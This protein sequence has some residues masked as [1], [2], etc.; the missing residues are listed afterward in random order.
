[1][2]VHMTLRKGETAE[3]EFKR[4]DAEKQDTK[5][6]PLEWWKV[7]ES[8][9]PRVAALAREYLA[10]PATSA[11]VERLFSSVGLVKTDDRPRLKDST[12][13]DIMW[14]KENVFE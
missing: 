9:F 13:V 2:I 5:C 8:K 10:A 12:L 7:N 6:H 1:M 14:V 4:Y 3:D 11:T